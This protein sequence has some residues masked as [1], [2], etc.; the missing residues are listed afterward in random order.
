MRIRHGT[1]RGEPGKNQTVKIAESEPLR[2]FSSQHIEPGVRISAA[3]ETLDRN[4][5]MTAHQ[6]SLR[7]SPMGAS[8]ARFAI[9]RQSDRVYDRDSLLFRPLSARP[10]MGWLGAKTE[11]GEFQPSR[12]RQRVGKISLVS[13]VR[14]PR[15]ALRTRHKNE[16]FK[17]KLMRR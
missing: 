6:I 1:K 4:S 14:I 11:S 10:A 7:M 12:L 16:L 5:P 3:S 15:V 2:R 13:F 9:L 8:I 17:Q